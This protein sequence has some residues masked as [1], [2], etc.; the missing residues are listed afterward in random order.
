MSKIFPTALSALDGL[1]FDGMTIC[2]GG[3]GLCGI[4]EK[5]IDAIEASGITGL[6][7]AS[8]NAGIDGIGLGDL[9]PSEWSKISVILDHE[10]VWKWARSTSQERSLR[11]SENSGQLFH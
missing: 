9:P 6:T 11:V 7:I 5:L 8:N 10:G 3:F 1:L 2:A 4:P